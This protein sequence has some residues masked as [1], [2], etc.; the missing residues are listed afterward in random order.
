[1]RKE[2]H[3]WFGQSMPKPGIRE[4][5]II[6]SY[7]GL[8]NLFRVAKSMDQY[9]DGHFFIPKNVIIHT[10]N[11]IFA[12]GRIIEEYGFRLFIHPAVGDMFEITFGE[13]AN[14]NRE[15][16]PI[17]CLWHMLLSGVFDTDECNV[18]SEDF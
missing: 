5:D 12:N 7:D 4:G 3:I 14:T 18:I 16:K 17:H 1:M 13:C 9:S 6:E 15:I 10:H 8:A 2:L 11:I